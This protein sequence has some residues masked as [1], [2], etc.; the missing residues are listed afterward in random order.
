MPP[1]RR[2]GLP[3][4]GVCVDSDAPR[5]GGQGQRLGGHVSQRLAA[6]PP[7][8]LAQLCPAQGLDAVRGLRQVEG[9][10]LESCEGAEPRRVVGMP[11]EVEQRLEQPLP[12]EGARWLGRTR[13][14][15]TTVVIVLQS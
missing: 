14:I 12:E 10:Q 5:G 9:D 8:A 2:L 13:V 7:Q 15:R 1:P 4:V 3:R 11:R 6:V